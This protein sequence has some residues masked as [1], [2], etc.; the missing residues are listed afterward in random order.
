VPVKEL[1]D[2]LGPPTR[3]AARELYYGPAAG[4]GVVLMVNKAGR[5]TGFNFA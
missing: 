2:L 1:T 4:E 5:I 3:T